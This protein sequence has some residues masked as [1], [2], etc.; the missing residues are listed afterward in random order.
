[1]KRKFISALL[2]GA[3]CITPS[4]VLVS[5]DDYDSD[6]ENLQQQITANAQ[7]LEQ[8]S[9][10]KL[11]N[12]AVEIEALKSAQKGL[13]DAYKNADEANKQT[14]IAAAKLLVEKAKADLESALDAANKRIAEQGKTVET[15]LKNDAEMQNAITTAK[16]KAEKAY[17]LAEQAMALSKANKEEL[18]KVANELKSIKETLEKQIN[19][20]SD[21]V[22]KLTEKVGELES[23]LTAQEGTL[24]DYINAKNE[25][26]DDKLEEEL[27]KFNGDI[28]AYKKDQAKKIEEL[29]TSIANLKAEVDTNKTELQNLVNAEVKKLTEKIG[30]LEAALN[31]EIEKLKTAYN[32]LDTKDKEL[33]AQIS[34]LEKGLEN[35][36]AKLNEE[37][38]KKIA[39]V[40]GLVDVLYAN[41]ANLITGVIVQDADSEFEAVYAQVN[42]FNVNPGEGKT[43]FDAENVKQRKVYFPY[44]NAKNASTLFANQYNVQEKAG[45]IFATINPNSV[46]FKGQTLALLNSQDAANSEYVLEKTAAANKLITRAEAK[47]GNGL[48]EMAVTNTFNKGDYEAVK[49]QPKL[50]EKVVYALAATDNKTLGK[51][52]KPMGRKVY[53]KY[54]IKT[55]ATAATALTNT[56]FELIG[57]DAQKNA[58][59]VNYKFV[60]QAATAGDLTGTLR[61]TPVF[62]A[63]KAKGAKKV[64]RKYLVCTK[65]V[66][67]GKPNTNVPDAVNAM[68]T[69]KGFETVLA[70]GNDLFNEIPVVISEKY[71][72]YIFTYDYYIWNYDGSIYKNTYTV[73]YTK[74]MIE[75]QTIAM[76]HTPQSNAV[77]TVSE[78]NPA[79][80]TLLCMTG[81]NDVFVKNT[82]KLTVG[83]ATVAGAQ[84]NGGEFTK[85]TFTNG[86]K[87]A[88]LKTLDINL[89]QN[90]AEQSLEGNFKASDIKTLSVTYDPA[91]VTFDKVYTLPLNFKNPQTNLVNTVNIQFTMKRPTFFDEFI[92]RI[93]NAF[94]GNITIAW[95]AYDASAKG[96]AYYDLSGSYNNVNKDLD[97]VNGVE[98]KILFKDLT[99]YNKANKNE[100]YKPLKGDLGNYT[101]APFQFNHLLYVP[102]AAVDADSKG[103]K[104]AYLYNLE[105]GV[106]YFGLA[107]LYAATEKFQLKWYSPIYHADLSTKKLNIGYPGK[108]DVT[109]ADITSDDPSKSGKQNI[110]YLDNRDV[111]IT[112][113]EVKPIMN[114]NV[115]ADANTGLFTKYQVSAD[116]KK[117]EFETTEKAALTGP[118]TV[119]FHMVVTDVFGCVKTHELSVTV[120]PNEHHAQKK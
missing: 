38:A 73:I 22:T 102:N 28:E 80:N 61:L 56:D 53:S 35:A 75:T 88:E 16:E 93:T 107:N 66:Q 68:N 120:D 104:E 67:P 26:Q 3:L 19:A 46:D 91:K 24:R 18:T 44:K 2:F 50:N 117:L 10:E 100:A 41:L 12:V 4:S 112:H 25:E 79:F 108:L 87:D 86:K 1:M 47:K 111:R 49:K 115:F 94:D 89:M 99:V 63:H 52:G 39:A 70:E 59:G 113:V 54:E 14:V 40:N 118:A 72:N 90:K 45:F 64:Y 55:N 23:S 78:S 6:I 96:Y 76:T 110:L 105:A 114:G 92:Q 97:K 17:G 101:V 48:Y 106:K 65:A 71:N 103:T 21:K 60:G 58:D 42:K 69:N 116:G 31:T 27:D 5:C 11:K 43:Y 82:T 85:I 51:D 20:L 32:N 34:E 81:K 7:T 9:G 33:Q 84:I 37:I 77:Q 13:E 109:N 62:D 74:P 8:L 30:S 57:V 119:K 95:A 29:K 36:E 83:A 98:S 15:L